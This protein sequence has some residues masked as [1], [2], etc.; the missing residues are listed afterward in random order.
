[1]AEDKDEKTKSAGKGK[2]KDPKKEEEPAKAPV[3]EKKD[4]DFRYIVRLVNSDLD[5]N[6]DI[7]IALSGIKGVGMRTAEIIARMTG[8]PRSTKIGDLPEE[9]TAELE[10]LVLD[11]SER[12]PHWM[13]NRQHDWSSGADIHIVGVDVELYKRDDVNLMRMIRCYKGVRH[14][15][16]QK[17]RGQRSRANGR[18]GLTLGVIK[19]KEQPGGA[20]LKKE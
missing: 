11:Y 10:K 6:K 13:V 8:I 7:V 2:K 1:M 18:S 17:V 12:A 20:A 19:R 4:K 5:G 16:G 15:T 3:T 14:E 9:K